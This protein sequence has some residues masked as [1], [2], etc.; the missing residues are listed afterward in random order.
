LSASDNTRFSLAGERTLSRRRFVGISAAV[1]GATL[2][3]WLWVPL[4]TRAQTTAMPS[5]RAQTATATPT[6]APR[7]KIVSAD[8][9]AQ[10]EQ[11]FLEFP[12][13]SQGSLQPIMVKGESIDSVHLGAIELLAAE[14]GMQNSGLGSSATAGTAA[15]TAEFEMLRITKPVDAA[16]PAIFL[17]CASGASFPSAN[18]YVRK[19]G[20]EEDLVYRFKLVQPTKVQTAAG[21][22]DDTPQEAI[23]FV[24]GAMQVEYTQQGAASPMTQAWSVVENQPVFDVTR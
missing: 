19:T 24:F 21:S 15:G 9:G 6:H 11:A 23:D 1:A 17:A 5:I 16:S 7:P 2:G 8:A 13:P 4:T 14:L 22:G 10:G 20:G 3:T 18:L 12:E